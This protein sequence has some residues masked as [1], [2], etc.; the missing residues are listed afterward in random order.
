MDYCKQ[1]ASLNSDISYVLVSLKDLKTKLVLKDENLV[2]F[3]M[4]GQESF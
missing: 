4:V 2:G 3:G 1:Q